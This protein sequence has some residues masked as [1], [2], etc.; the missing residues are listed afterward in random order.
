M[1]FIIATHNKKKLAE[2][3]RILNPIG[4]EV[5]TAQLQEVDETGTTF[6]ENAY[7][8]ANVACKETGLPAIADDSGLAVD[9]L[10]GAPGIYS[11]RYA[12]E[13]ATDLQ[14]MEKLLYELKDVPKEKR[15]AR[16]VCSICCVFPNGDYITA[17]GTCE[18]TIAFELTGDG[19]F[20]YD[21][22]F[23]V[24]EQSFGQLSDE[25]KDRISHRGKAL[26]LFSQKLQEY[27]NN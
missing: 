10:N 26:M 2:M 23:L 24:G 19:G 6:A 12:G 18:G 8:K 21:P 3:E 16:F 27:L 5:S 13:H 17:E 25:E 20:G 22:I 1:K 4:I 9:A 14:K 11:A 15:T 7:L